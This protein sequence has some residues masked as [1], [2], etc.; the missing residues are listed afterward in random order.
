MGHL[1]TGAAAAAMLAVA[2]HCLVQIARMLRTGRSGIA[3]EVVHVAMAATMA[4]MFLGLLSTVADLIALVVFALLAVWL[5]TDLLLRGDRRSVPLCVSSLAMAVMAWA[6]TP[7]A[8]GAGPGA[9]SG[10]SGMSMPGMGVASAGLAPWERGLV[11]LSLVLMVAVAGWS[12]RGRRLRDALMGA[13]M[14]LMLGSTL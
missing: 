11:G 2:A 5:V 7:A 9:M 1:L 6:M 8:T 4:A 10:M 14:A 12:L 13:A 3:P